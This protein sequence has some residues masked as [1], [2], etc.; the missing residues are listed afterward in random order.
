[1]LGWFCGSGSIQLGLCDG[2]E[3]DDRSAGHLAYEAALVEAG[4]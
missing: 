3:S 1:V 2:F 4:G